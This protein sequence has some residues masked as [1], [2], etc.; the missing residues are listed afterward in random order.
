MEFSHRYDSQ[1]PSCSQ[2]S[3]SARGWQYSETPEMHGVLSLQR[4]KHLEFDYTHSESILDVSRFAK[5]VASTA[6]SHR[7]PAHSR[8]RGATA[9]ASRQTTHTHRAV[10]RLTIIPI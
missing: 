9:D 8:R 2:C 1:S 5:N 10:L 6:H 3:P 7:S 4:S